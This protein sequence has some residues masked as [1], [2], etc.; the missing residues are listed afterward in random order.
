MLKHA[1]FPLERCDEVCDWVADP[2]VKFHWT[3]N[4]FEYPVSGSDFRHHIERRR[5]TG[6]GACFGFWLDEAPEDL[7]AYAELGT[8]DEPNLSGKVE[9]MVVAPSMRGRGIGRAVI[10][11]LAHAFFTDARR[12]NRLELVV[13]T[14]NPSALRCYQASGFTEEGVLRESRLHG[15]EWKSVALMSLLR[16]EWEVGR[17]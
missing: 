8:W 3:A 4:S 16:S 2:Q 10:A 9:R 13:A 14:D 12:M 11:M 7:A 15:A 1:N 17:G 6:A 5:S